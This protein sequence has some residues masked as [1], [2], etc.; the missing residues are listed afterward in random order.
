MRAF[1]EGLKQPKALMMTSRSQQTV[2]LAGHATR[3]PFQKLVAHSV[4]HRFA[5]YLLLRSTPTCQVL[6]T[7]TVAS[8]IRYF[9]L[10]AAGSPLRV[11]CCLAR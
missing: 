9:S 2:I 8:L 7:V 6:Q 10:W 4:W 11:S 3:E 1:Q 5:M